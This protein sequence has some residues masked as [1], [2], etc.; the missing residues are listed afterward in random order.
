MFAPVFQVQ[1]HAAR[2]PGRGN[3]SEWPAFLAGPK[4]NALADL[5]S[6]VQRHL[7]QVVE[8]LS[9]QP[10]ARHPQEIA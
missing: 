3:K 7:N 4:T 9:L 6:Q 2:A 5:V 10:S 8:F 1:S